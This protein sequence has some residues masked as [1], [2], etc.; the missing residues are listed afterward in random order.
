MEVLSRTRVVMKESHDGD[1]LIGDSQ[2]KDFGSP[3]RQGLGNV[4]SLKKA[5]GDEIAKAHYYDTCW[6]VKCSNWAMAGSTWPVKRSSRAME[7]VTGA[8]ECSTWEMNCSTWA[9]ENL[10]WAVNTQ[11]WQ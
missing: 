6:A 11:Y 4:Q 1:I 5:V 10:N 2:Y 3:T 8:V 9:V 7:S